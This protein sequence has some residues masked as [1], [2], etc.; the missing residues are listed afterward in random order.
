MSDKAET[1]PLEEAQARAS[2]AIYPKVTKELIEGKIF[3]VQYTYPVGTTLTVCVITMDNG[4]HV[5]GKAAPADPR[6]FDPEIGKR[7]AYEDAFKQ[8]WQF[9]GYLLKEM[10]HGQRPPAAPETEAA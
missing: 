9:E 3:A 5:L 8:L 10:L 6:N 2:A 1:I 4:F 7:Y